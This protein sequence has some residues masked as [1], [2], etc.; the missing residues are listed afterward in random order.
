[1]TP[2][3]QKIADIDAALARLREKTIKATES[4]VVGPDDEFRVTL[5]LTTPPAEPFKCKAE[6][7]GGPGHQSRSLCNRKDRHVI[8]GN[9]WIEEVVEEWSGSETHY[10]E[11]YG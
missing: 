2:A 11:Y 5:T 4:W 1:M 8:D 6:S 3:E 10:R 9:H 7:W